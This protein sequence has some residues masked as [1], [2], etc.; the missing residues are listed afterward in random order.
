MTEF[1][2]A[3]DARWNGY[4]IAPGLAPGMDCCGNISADDDHALDCANEPSFS[5]SVCDS[6]GSS[7]GGDR[8]A[9]HAISREGGL[10]ITHIEIC[11]DCVV[12]HANG[13]EPE[14]WG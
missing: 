13:E 14:Q 5:W 2:D 6:C 8:H 7:L 11:V 12:W 10:D 9:A 1:T 4:T 3:I